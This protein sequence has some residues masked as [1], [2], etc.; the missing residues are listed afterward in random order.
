MTSLTLM[1]CRWNIERWLD[2]PPT[3]SSGKQSELYSVSNDSQ[4]S[5]AQWC[6]ASSQLHLCCMWMSWDPLLVQVMWS[7]LAL[8]G[9]LCQVFYNDQGRDAAF[10]PKC[11]H[12]LLFL[13]LAFAFPPIFFL[14]LAQ[15]GHQTSSVSQWWRQKDVDA[16]AIMSVECRE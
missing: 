6:W 10:Q 4:H 16:C 5:A 3:P 14:I 7:P 8:I 2:E 12:C 1:A 15:S 9:C 13:L 11:A